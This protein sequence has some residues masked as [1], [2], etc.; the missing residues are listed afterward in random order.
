LS[1]CC[2]L[3]QQP[4]SDGENEPIHAV[5]VFS[6]API[7]SARLKMSHLA[8]KLPCSDPTGVQTCSDKVTEIAPCQA[9]AAKAEIE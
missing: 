1:R 6:T 2:C 9:D 5:K 8:Q 3:D 7:S 4:T